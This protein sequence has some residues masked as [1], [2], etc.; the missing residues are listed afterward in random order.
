MA[1]AEESRA[2]VAGEMIGEGEERL[3][4]LRRALLRQCARHGSGEAVPRTREPSTVPL[5]IISGQT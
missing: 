3:R 1:D 5:R 2:P 4:R